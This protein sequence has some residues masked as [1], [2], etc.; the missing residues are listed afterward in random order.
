MNVVI[1]KGTQVFIPVHGLHRDEK[2]YPQPEQFIPDRFSAE[3][4]AGKTFSDRPYIPFGSG[5]RLC[6]GLRLGKLQVKIGVISMLQRY[7]FALGAKYLENELELS[8]GT[9][10]ATPKYGLPLL[11]TKRQF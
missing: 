4:A 9:I 2:Y 6:M 10:I 7:N 3:N 1:E 11:A 8:A 5:Q